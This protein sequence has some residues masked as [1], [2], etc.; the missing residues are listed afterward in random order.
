MI[1]YEIINGYNNKKEGIECMICHHYYFKDNFNYQPYVCDKCHDFSL[2]IMDLSDFF[3]LNIKGNAYRVYISGLDKKVAII[4][5]KKSNLDNKGVL[6]M[7]FNPNINP[8]DVIEEGAFGGTCFRNIH[9]NVNNRFYKNTWKEFK[10]LKDV[11]KKYYCSDFYDVNLNYYNVKVGW[12]Q[13]YYRYWKGRR[14]NDDK[15]QINRWKR[16]VS[17]FIGILKKL[18]SK[19]K[20]SK[21]IRQTLLHWCYELN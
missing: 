13:W 19:G 15:R 16:I 3:I 10:E 8:I 18:N 21:K 4:I 12:F 20:Y 11:D 2:T 17:R 9:S 7:K 6:Q 1:S 5:F 14:S